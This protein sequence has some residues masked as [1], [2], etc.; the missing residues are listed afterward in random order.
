M[1]LN[2][3]LMKSNRIF[4][5]LKNGFRFA[6]TNQP[7]KSRMGFYFMVSLSITVTT[8]LALE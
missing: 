4:P 7:K 5:K 2:K 6:S 8:K 1:K 3:K